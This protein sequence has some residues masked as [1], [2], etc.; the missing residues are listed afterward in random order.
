MLYC[1]RWSSNLFIYWVYCSW[2]MLNPCFDCGTLS[3]ISTRQLVFIG[4]RALLHLLFGPVTY[5]WKC[6]KPR[7]NE[8]MPE[9]CHWDVICRLKENIYWPVFETRVEALKWKLCFNIRTHHLQRLSGPHLRGSQKR[10]SWAMKNCM[11][12]NSFFFL[13]GK[14]TLQQ[15]FTS[16]LSFFPLWQ[17]VLVDTPNRRVQPC[18]RV[19]SHQASRQK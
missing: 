11:K 1:Q 3:K 13:G 7:S 6:L 17:F 2:T 14:A 16:L 15:E 9:F 19:G 10:I 8:S 4:E 5:E 18:F 12:A